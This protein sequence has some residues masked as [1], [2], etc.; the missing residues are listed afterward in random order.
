MRLSFQRV[1][2]AVTSVVLLVGLIST[3]SSSAN[4]PSVGADST[5]TSA[6]VEVPS[7]GHPGGRG[8]D[9]CDYVPA[10]LTVASTNGEQ[11]VFN[12]VGHYLFSRFC[13][14]ELQ[15]TVWLGMH[16]PG[17]VLAM[18]RD[19]FVRVLPEPTPQMIWPDPDFDWAYA[20]VPIDF[21]ADPG[22]WRTFEDTA[23]AA[24]PLQTVSVTIRAEPRE[25]VYTAGDP[26]ATATAASAACSGEEPLAAYDP[27]LP[28]ACSYTY[29]NA[30]S[31]A[32]NG[33]AFPA[34]LAITWDIEYWSTTHPGFA[35][36]L[37][38]IT[39]E[40]VFPIEVAEVKVLGTNHP[41]P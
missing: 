18:A 34:S 29:V 12:G 39:R 15:G 17:D 38:P 41:Q 24:N 1:V 16:T 19:S 28:G 22:D 33:R 36:S 8:S 31:T 40:T 2:G 30:S 35:G 13:N 6:D 5:S 3:P 21:R 9:G 10:A 7:S 23:S 11:S 37:P 4:P 32:R 14:G 26:A 20:Q 25:L 27:Y